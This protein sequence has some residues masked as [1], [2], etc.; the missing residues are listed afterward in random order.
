MT[1]AESLGVQEPY[2]GLRSFESDE[3]YL[4]YGRETH[5]AELL[6]RLMRHRFIGVVGVS[7]C[8]KSS[9]VRAGLIPALDRGGLPGASSRWRTATMHPGNAPLARLGRALRQADIKTES[10]AALDT[11]LA[12]SSVG[13][14]TVA[15]AA[16][17][18]DENF[19]LVVDQFEEIF[20]FRSGSLRGD[21]GAE[22]ALF[23]AALLRASETV[24][25][26]IFV[27][28]T[29]RSDHL[30]DCAEFPGLT[31]ALNRGQFL[32]PRLTREQ[33]RDAVERP[34]D[35]FKLRAST[36]LTQ[37]LL[38]DTGGSSDQLPL[39]QHALNRTF[40]DLQESRKKGVASNDRLPLLREEGD[41]L[42]AHYL[43]AGGL[44]EA[45]N[46]HAEHVFLELLTKDEQ[47]W[48]ERVFRCITAV[49]G[50]RV[51][52]R[53]TRIDRLLELVVAKTNDARQAVANAIAVL[54][55]PEHS[56]LMMTDREASAEAMVDI[57]HESLITSGL[58]SNGGFA[59]DVSRRG[60]PG[61]GRGYGASEEEERRREAAN[62]VYDCS[63]HR[64]GGV[65]SDSVE[66]TD[67]SGAAPSWRMRNV[68]SRLAR[69]TRSGLSASWDRLPVCG[70]NR[71]RD[72]RWRLPTWPLFI[73][74][75]GTPH[76]IEFA[77]LASR[78]PWPS[79][80]PATA[81]TDYMVSLWKGQSIAISQAR[82]TA[83]SGQ[84]QE[85]LAQLDTSTRDLVDLRTQLQ[86]R[87]G[88]ANNDADRKQLQAQLQEVE[89]RRKTRGTAS[90]CPYTI[91]RPR[92]NAQVIGS[93][94]SSARGRLRS[95]DGG[96]RHAH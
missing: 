91:W 80:W 3:S 11:E 38:S 69:G 15:S 24:A 2:P 90:D 47:A 60:L 46:K 53:P 36:Q 94:G 56:F 63:P 6:Q 26:S 79:S 83:V 52:R 7:G 18:A 55:R 95:G 9:L 25:A 75:A 70:S 89:T 32:V 37:R 27:V 19:L 71:I 45:L 10:D 4:F 51:V 41:L 23:V 59:T 68:T 58:V 33:L 81:C 73:K 22:A 74:G 12:L 57:S 54:C 21:G 67:S 88:A 61:R 62:R 84:I 29:M 86:E 76:A 82:E 13:L 49:D 39:L 93:T 72:R 87:Q 78:L 14:A 43:A 40:R 77:P 20:R 66:W 1:L 44:A 16:L 65:P 50:G 28:L 17:A 48:I 42:L 34:L 5:V 31:E 92:R 85:Q 30:G 96:A 64:R 35:I 8:G